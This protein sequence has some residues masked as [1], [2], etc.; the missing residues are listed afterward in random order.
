[1]RLGARAESEPRECGGCGIAFRAEDTR[2]HCPVC[3]WAVRT[4]DR[5]TRLPE[6]LQGPARVLRDRWAAVLLGIAVVG[7]VAVLV[8]VSVSTR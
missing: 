4:E 6:K 3:D 8:A 2:G 5:S 1:M 7:N